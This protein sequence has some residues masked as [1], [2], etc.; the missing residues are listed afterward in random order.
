MHIFRNIISLINQIWMCVSSNRSS[1]KSPWW[2]FYFSYFH[3]QSSFTKQE[4]TLRVFTHT[5]CVFTQPELFSMSSRDV[6]LNTWSFLNKVIMIWYQ[7]FPE[8][9]SFCVIA[10]LCFQIIFILW[11]QYDYLLSS[12][13]CVSLVNFFLFFASDSGVN[14]TKKVRRPWTMAEKLDITIR[15]DIGE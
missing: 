15:L 10:I 11:S 2:L 6:Y 8:S 14:V 5:G 3:L 1:N 9:C 13:F 12:L 7:G 4:T